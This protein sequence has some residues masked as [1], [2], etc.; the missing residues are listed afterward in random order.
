MPNPRVN[1]A[2]LLSPVEDGYVAYDPVA[3]NLHQLN[4]MAAL[5]TELSDGS[6]SIDEIGAL[7]R[8]LLPEDKAGEV[9]RWF[10]EGI[11]AGLLVWEGSEISARELTATE[12]ANL[13]KR[14]GD[15][16]NVQT[17]YL[18]AKKVV[19]MQPE[20]ANAWYRLGDFAQCLGRRDEARIAYQKYFEVNPDDGEIEHLLIALRDDAPPPRASDRAILH[21]Y[22]SFAES[23]ESRMLDD[24]KYAG[25]QRIEDALK[26]V[27]GEKTEMTV[28]D[29]GCGSGL[30]GVMIRP[31]AAR[32]TGVDL[33]PEM[34]ERARAR[35]IYDRLEQGE[36]TAWLDSHD[37]TFDLILSCDCLIYFGDLTTITRMAARRLPPGGVFVLSM[38]RGGKYP[39]FLSDTGRYTHHP[40][41][42]REVAKA[43]GLTLMQLNE[44]F[45]RWEYAEEVMGL[46]AVLQKPV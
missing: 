11:Q 30:S 26:A 18:C 3:D 6:R 23:Y 5:L 12:L 27:I 24:L 44:A 2:I 1:P 21:I 25:P 4:P 43:A 19:E 46:Y 32:L 33:S 39:Y 15:I 14:L 28:L 22:K 41:H 20:N 45:L 42:V 31:R 7:V 38:E 29:L 13:A 10:D 8:P 34:L 35:G 37:E 40:D 36:I 17:G 16:G 9:A